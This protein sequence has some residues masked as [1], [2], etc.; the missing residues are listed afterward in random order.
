MFF[1]DVSGLVE[2]V[3]G[4]EGLFWE[5]GGGLFKGGFGRE[6]FGCVEFLL[7]LFLLIIIL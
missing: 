4:L 3:L 5:F 2:V 1:F 6:F 7:F